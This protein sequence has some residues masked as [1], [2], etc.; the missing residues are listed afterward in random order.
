MKKPLF[1]ETFA[2]FFLVGALDRVANTFNLYWSVSEFDSIVHFLGGGAVS[3]FFLWF[4]F[5][6][7]V[8]SPQKRDLRYFIIVSLLGTIF[9]STLWEIYEL[10]LGEARTYRETYAFDT[11]LDFVMDLLGA[12]AVCLYGYLKELK[13]KTLNLKFKL[14]E[15]E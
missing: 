15:N 2:L 9:V 1:I 3:L 6:S 13:L 8:F 7:G 11:T 12:M 14:N 5:Y 4:Y 10:M